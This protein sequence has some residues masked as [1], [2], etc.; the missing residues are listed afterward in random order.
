[1]L[2]ANQASARASS[3]VRSQSSAARAASRV[4]GAASG[5]RR[6]SSSGA[7]RCRIRSACID[8]G[9]AGAYFEFASAT[10]PT[11]ESRCPTMHEP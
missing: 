3:S 5:A 2:S 8:R 10:T 1:M 6:A 9:V 7:S 11:P 4:R